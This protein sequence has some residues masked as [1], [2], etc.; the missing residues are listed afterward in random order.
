MLCS[1]HVGAAQAEAGA[2]HGEGAG[3]LAGVDEPGAL[4][5]RR[6]AAAGRAAQ[7][8]VQRVVRVCTYRPEARCRSPMCALIFSCNFSL[9]AVLIKLYMNYKRFVRLY[10]VV[11]HFYLIFC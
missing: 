1:R 2:A 7:G 3:E 4:D 5:I 8:A 9:K 6:R 11:N 10:E